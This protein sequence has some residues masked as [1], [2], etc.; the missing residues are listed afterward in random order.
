M[1]FAAMDPDAPPNYRTKEAKKLPAEGY[2]YFRGPSGG[3]KTSTIFD[4]ACKRPLIYV[5]CAYNSE[6]A[7]ARTADLLFERLVDELNRQCVS[8]LHTERYTLQQAQAHAEYLI[9]ADICVRL[10]FLLHLLRTAAS[11]EEQITAE[12]ILLAQLYDAQRMM[13]AWFKRLA[14]TTPIGMDALQE[15]TTHVS[16]N[17][18]VEL[19][20]RFRD[21]FDKP[22]SGIAVAIDEAQAAARLLNEHD[23]LGFHFDHAARNDERRGLLYKYTTL[24]QQY[25]RLLVITGT[26]LTTD[27][28]AQ[29]PTDIAKAVTG[30]VQLPYLHESDVR[31]R[32][33]RVLAVTDEDLA[34]VRNL[35]LLTGRCRWVA[36]LVALLANKQPWPKSDDEPVG[37][38]EAKGNDSPQTTKAVLLEKTIA[39]LAENVS[40][41]LCGK[42]EA[43]LNHERER[44]RISALPQLLQRLHIVAWLFHQ[45]GAGLSQEFSKT[46]VFELLGLGLVLLTDEDVTSVSVAL[47]PIGIRALQKLA[48]TQKWAPLSCLAD[49]LDN[50]L[51]LN[52]V[53]LGNEFETLVAAALVDFEGTVADLITRANGGIEPDNLPQDH[54]TRRRP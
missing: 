51:A 3:G 45:Q 24:W 20:A 50:N 18:C 54:W 6:L 17:L 26:N 48:P 4:Y 49:K 32:L 46:E 43:L 28:A 13:I 12:Q 11:Q 23:D 41:A 9:L 29:V 15:L 40:A 31:K 1:R 44:A 36:A 16:N 25:A 53:Q 22:I 10:L 19:A 42:L 33:K 27:T 39:D 5:A 14:V 30:S 21:Q 8:P 7:E 52:G 47:D 2:L 34:G 35:H 38:Q 37:W